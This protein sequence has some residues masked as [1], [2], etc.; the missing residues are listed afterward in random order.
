MT[1]HTRIT[2]LITDLNYGGAEVQVVELASRLSARGWQA[3]V[4]SML[5]PRAFV[6]DLS[7]AGVPVR[8]LN[9][10]RGM[11]SPRAVFDLAAILRE[12]RPHIL[13]RHMFQRQPSASVSVSTRRPRNSGRA[14]STAA[15]PQNGSTYP[16]GSPSN[17]HTICA[18][19]AFPP[20]HGNGARR[21]VKTIFLLLSPVGLPRRV[22][23]S[24]TI[25]RC[26]RHGS[27]QGHR[28]GA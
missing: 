11:P 20:N 12:D 23:R 4:V 10:R 13:H 14:S 6:A 3:S 9:M 1:A 17:D 5:Q 27:P 8:S 24:A 18:A 19:R 16:P 2:F 25:L 28:R 7:A 22:R 21:S 26:R 15:E